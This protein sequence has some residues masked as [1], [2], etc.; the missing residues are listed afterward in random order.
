MKTMLYVDGFN[1]Y[2]GLLRGSSFKWLD[3]GMMG[4]LLLPNDE[5][6][7]IR[8]FSAKV[9]SRANDPQK[10]IRQQV[11]WRALRT[12]PN[13]Q[14]IEGHYA[15]HNKWMRMAH[16]EPGQNPYVKVIKT[17]EKG[18]DVN[19]AVHLLND[20]YQKRF[21][22]GVVVS[23]DSDLLSAMQIVRHDL[24]LRIGILNPQNNP[25]RDLQPCALFIKTIRQGVLRASQ[26]PAKMTDAQGE[27]H[28]PPDW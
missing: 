4:R 3:I 25:S 1:L 10:H 23:N 14:I 16:P 11:Y 26:F 27:F 12:I 28:K 6:V 18:S 8:Y 15:E 21:E 2:Y 9:F 5:I 20:A 17:E 13:L 24:G 22:L 19:L 7:G